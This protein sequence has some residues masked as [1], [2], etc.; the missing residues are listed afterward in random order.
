MNES[1]RL[2]SVNFIAKKATWFAFK[3]S[4]YFLQK[5]NL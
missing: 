1:V 2:H 5:T 4:I 3:P